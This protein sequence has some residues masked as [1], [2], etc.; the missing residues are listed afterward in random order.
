MNSNS[1]LRTFA[2]NAFGLLQKKFER[3]HEETFRS[4]TEDVSIC[5]WWIEG[6]N[7]DEKELDGNRIDNYRILRSLL[8]PPECSLLCQWIEQ[9]I[10]EL[11]STV[12]EEYRKWSEM[13]ESTIRENPD[14]II[15]RSIPILSVGTKRESSWVVCIQSLP[16]SKWI[17]IR[18]Q[19]SQFM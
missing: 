9:T 3:H 13:I 19:F 15:S 2:E 12:G 11:D 16:T 14:S 18:H 6:W 7:I 17:L 1:A 10:F 4:F 5:K 8:T